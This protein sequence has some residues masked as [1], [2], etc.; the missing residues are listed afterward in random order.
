MS[1]MLPRSAVLAPEIT[2]VSSVFVCR[3]GLLICEFASASL[4]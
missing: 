3:M 2:R 4:P 1:R